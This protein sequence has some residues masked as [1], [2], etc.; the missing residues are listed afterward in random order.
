MVGLKTFWILISALFLLAACVPQTKQTECKANEAFNASLR[1]CVPIVGGPSS[2]INV[3]TYTPQFTQTRYKDDATTLVF[4]IAVS[5]PYNQSYSVEWVRVFNAAPTSMC[6]NALTCTTSASFLGNVLGEIGT[7]IITAKIIDGNGTVVDSHNFELKINEL[8]R[9]IINTASLTPASYALDVYPTDAS[10]NFSFQIKNNNATISALDG[11]K[12]T[13]TVVKNGST[14]LT[15]NDPFSNFSPSGTN[16][17]YL[18]TS[19]TPAFDPDGAAFGVGSY[20]IRAVVQNSSPGEVVDEHQWNVIVKQ[21]DLANVTNVSGPAP[22]VTILAHNNVDYNDY[23]TYSWVY[24][25]TKPTFCVNVD[26]RDGTYAGDGLA[27]AVKFYLDGAG[28]D[29]CTKRTADTPGT[30]TV[31]LLDAN[32]CVGSVTPSNAD[33]TLMNSLKFTNASST[34]AANHTVVARIF[35]ERTTYELQPSDVLSPA[36]L[37]PIVWTVLNNPVNV[38]PVMSFGPM[39]NVTSCVSAGA[40]TRSNCKVNQGDPNVTVTFT[41]TDD[42]YSPS[43][44]EEEFMWDFKLKMNGSDIATPPKVTSCTKALGA[45]IPA[46]TTNW[47]CALEIPHY[48]ASGPLNPAGPFQI[49]A[50]MQDS[51]SPV[52]GVAA[53]SQSLT[54]NLVV[55]ETNAIV[56]GATK[57]ILIS[58]QA[59]LSTTSHISRDTPLPITYMDPAGS[60]FA[61]EM[62]TITFRLAVRD[63]ELDDFNYKVFKCG[64][65]SNSTTCA[66]PDVS[67]IVSTDYLRALFPAATLPF[68]DTTYTDS[69]LVNAT[70]YTLPETLLLGIG[71]DVNKTTS[72]PVYFR[73]DLTDKPTTFPTVAA[74]TDSQIFTVYVRN[75]NP[76]PVISVA[77]ASPAANTAGTAYKVVSGLPFSI[78]P[79]TV[80]D[81]STDTLENTIAYQWYATG[82]GGTTWTAISGAVTKNLTWTPDD[83]APALIELKLCV[84]D[85]AAANPVVSP[86]TVGANCTTP[87]WFIAPKSYLAKPT[88]ASP[89]TNV[90]S[91]VAV[92]N[93]VFD[94]DLTQDVI[95]TAYVG[96]TDLKIYVN[97]IVRDVTFAMNV[98]SFSTV[99]FDAVDGAT[100]GIVTGISLTGTTDSLYVAYGASVT[101]TPTSLLPRI[102]RINKAY[103]ALTVG[104]K[105]GLAHKGKFGFAYTDIV[106]DVS[107]CATCTQS[108]GTSVA[109]PVITIGA[110][111]LSG[112]VTI[113]GVTF[114][115]VAA[116]ATPLQVCSS[117]SC[118][119]DDGADSLAAK[120][121]SYNSDSALQGITAFVNGAGNQVELHGTSQFDS[122]VINQ[123]IGNNGI[124]NI[125]ISGG[126]WYLPFINSSLTGTAQN[127]I[128]IVKGNVDL[129]LQAVAVTS[130]N[131]TT[132]GQVAVFD[133]K[134][135]ASDDLI[136]AS[137]SGNVATAGRAKLSRLFNSAGTYADFVGPAVTT[138]NIFGTKLF[139]EIDL[140]ADT[141]GNSSLFVLAKDRDSGE[142]N[143]GRY[144]ANLTGT[145]TENLI[146]NQLVTSDSTSTVI[147]DTLMTNPALVAVPNSSD[148]RVFFNS[149]G[150]PAST[151][152][153]RVARWK[154]DNTFTCGS[155]EAIGLA[156]TN[157]KVA[158]SN[159]AINSTLGTA[160]YVL[161]ENQKDIAFIFMNYLNGAN[162]DP[163]LGLINLRT[164]TIQSTTVDTGHLFRPA[165]AK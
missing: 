98:T 21:P 108:A 48:I 126:V 127:N 61:T 4:T 24:S 133:S 137:I 17:A 34:V 74:K 112:T 50:T 90:G 38:A 20:I 31:C 99:S 100:P 155:C 2:F 152:K 33:A 121:N 138:I 131:L 63:P 70:T 150:T 32:P 29:I 78:N 23:P 96:A 103:G 130:Q 117:A 134:I 85:R 9:P 8:P 97:K 110:P 165:F 30:D 106:V 95:Y 84:G 64:T 163:Q 10:V 55:T 88:P 162:L 16:T 45:T 140:A 115:A 77:G 161:N 102:R 12:T 13:W 107:A 26:D 71:S 156:G 76:A 129:K 75:Y 142:Y 157:S 67:P 81:A 62:E 132:I 143:I 25:G 109:V 146:M 83:S 1:T 89:V 151:N 119:A 111:G 144:T 43:A 53:A 6:G 135:N 66:N 158:V 46:Y 159:V 22:G 69:V 160:G 101:S 164:E 56:D 18:G 136:I 36:G 15:E 44:Q 147:S 51:G 57:N 153:T 73:V 54:W 94:G 148:A 42:F 124:G 58:P 113:N 39:T 116:P 105:T 149:V 141:T 118:S 35:D 7:H 92:W 104:E 125:F 52:G 120:I 27:L 128:T 82:D 114:T 87:S 72:V 49:V 145:T 122:I 79:G 40:F 3:S 47:S 5:N 37:Y 60:N 28:G 59:F 68:T 14:I 19:P 65:G 91:E 80:T 93:D 154:S 123:V 139:N 41:V 86:I 11:Y